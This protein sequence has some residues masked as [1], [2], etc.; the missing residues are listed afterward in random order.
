MSKIETKQKRLLS[1]KQAA[2]YT[3]L[4]VFTLRS[5]IWARKLKVVQFNERKMYIDINELDALI[6]KNKKY[7]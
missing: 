4:K 2:E 5:L 1:L 3:N 7:V 6:E